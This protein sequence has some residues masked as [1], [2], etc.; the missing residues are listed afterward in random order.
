MYD[1]YPQVGRVIA[2]GLVP[3]EESPHSAERDA[4]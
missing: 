2:V 4:G 1:T 3:I